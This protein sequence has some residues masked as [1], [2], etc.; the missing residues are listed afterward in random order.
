MS[1]SINQYDDTAKGGYTYEEKLKMVSEGMMDP[2]EIGMPEGKQGE[3]EAKKQ[4]PPEL[5]DTVYF[6]AK[7]IP[8]YLVA[9]NEMKK[10]TVQPANPRKWMADWT[11][12]NIDKHVVQARIES[13]NQQGG[14]QRVVTDP[15]LGMLILMREAADLLEAKYHELNK[16]KVITP[17]V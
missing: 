17:D 7:E 16:P 4:L 9:Q 15:F 10:L 12:D 3:V 8:I 1:D 13:G 11:D 6:I 2:K 14:M 5:G